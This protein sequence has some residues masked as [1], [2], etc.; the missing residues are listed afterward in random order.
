MRTAASGFVRIGTVMA[1]A[2]RR[3]PFSGLSAHRAGA[4][5]DRRELAPIVAWARVEPTRRK[6]GSGTYQTPVIE[7]RTVVVE[8]NRCGSGRC[9]EQAAPRIDRVATPYVSRCRTRMWHPELSRIGVAVLL[10]THSRL[11]IRRV[12]G[13]RFAAKY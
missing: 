4:A 7:S 1:V 6:L 3:F 2:R 9:G 11:G 13:I 8:A 12:L 5:S 10:V